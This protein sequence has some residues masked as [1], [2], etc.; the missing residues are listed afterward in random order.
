MHLIATDS[1]YPPHTNIEL[2]TR[3]NN[4]IDNLQAWQHGG[5]EWQQLDQEPDKWA[6]A[7]AVR[8]GEPCPVYNCHGLTFASRRTQVDGTSTMSIL[9]ILAEDGYTEV[10]EPLAKFGDVIVYYDSDGHAEHSGIVVSRPDA[11][12]IQVWSKWG[13]GYEMIHPA[14]SCLWGAFLK[15]FYRITKWNYEEVFQ[16]N[17]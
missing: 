9:Q 14:G 4:S 10:P 3:L 17:T 16:P 6:R 5:S 12:V 13:R 1:V 8:V 15:K 11:S 2:R 7:G